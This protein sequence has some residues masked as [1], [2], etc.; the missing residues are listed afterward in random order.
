MAS[1]KG[2]EFNPRY[3]HRSQIKFYVILIIVAIIMGLP[4]VYI[5]NH[6]FK[7]I[8]ELFAWPPRFFVINPTFKN[9]NDLF[10]MAS[11]TGI[12]ASRYLFNSIII[13]IIVVV[14][15]IVVG[16][17]AG[18]ALSKL[19]F[20]LK[21]P[22]LFA[23]N[24]AL[25]FVGTAVVIPRY[26]VVESLGLIDTFWVHIIP[27]LAIP[28]GLFLIKQ[29][30]DQIPEELIE[31]AKIDGAGH[32]RIYWS[33][34]LPLIKP[35][36]ATI[37]IVAFQSTWNNAEISTNYINRESIKTFAF[38]LQTLTNQGNAVAG[39]GISAAASLIMFVPNLVIFIF[40][41]KNVMNTMAHSGIK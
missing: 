23:N 28:V 25:M 39:Q 35:A 3:F 30:I 22:M 13:A 26:L 16:S 34:V 29:F 38:Y 1:F 8:D 17:M 11:T 21:K 41:Q 31:A 4:I 32:F 7:P 2:T 37:A 19:K 33:I 27:S 9:F 18:F 20:K 36:I 15:S 6:A 24:I 12:P 14:A 10:Q 40:L 5:F